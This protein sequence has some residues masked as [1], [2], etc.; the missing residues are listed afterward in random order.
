M[1]AAATQPSC[2]GSA[3]TRQNWRVLVTG[4]VGVECRC[5]HAQRKEPPAPLRSWGDRGETQGRGLWAAA[6][7]GRRFYTVR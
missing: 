3:E 7:G 6:G 4:E 1:K 5:L 2:E